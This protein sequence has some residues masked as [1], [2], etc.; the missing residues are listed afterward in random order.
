MDNKVKGVEIDPVKEKLIEVLAEV[1]PYS[2]GCPEYLVRAKA[3]MIA[4]RLIA[5][6][7]TVQTFGRWLKHNFLGHEQ[8]VCSKC[9]TL[10]SPQWKCCPI[11][12]A[13]MPEPPKEEK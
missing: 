9:Q 6:G 2:H 10:G 13:K 1:L 5:K 11:C 4:D 7:I 8:W 12:E 3:E